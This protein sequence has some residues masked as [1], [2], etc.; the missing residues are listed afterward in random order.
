MALVSSGQLYRR[1]TRV[2]RAMLSWWLNYFA[3]V[4][5]NFQC[6]DSLTRGGEVR[7][8]DSVKFSIF[9]FFVKNEQVV[10]RTSS[11]HLK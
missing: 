5:S 6:E 8:G 4:P 9:L 7:E 11:S 1:D 2:L 10:D 3:V